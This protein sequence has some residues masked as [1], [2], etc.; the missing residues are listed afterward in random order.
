MNEVILKMFFIAGFKASGPGFN[1]FDVENQNAAQIFENLKE[2]FEAVHEEV[3]QL[4]AQKKPFD[5]S[6]ISIE[7]I[8]IW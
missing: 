8:S 4:L 7:S 6:K 5:F 3:L 1:G 2:D